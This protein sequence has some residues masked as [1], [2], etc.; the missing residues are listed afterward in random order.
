[1]CLRTCARLTANFARYL[2]PT[3]E[4]IKGIEV[5]A[6]SVARAPEASLRVE[7]IY[8]DRNE[9]QVM[10]LRQSSAGW[11]IVR[12]ETAVNVKALV[13]YGTPV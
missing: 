5:R 8:A 1:M 2:K 11:K 6:A 7:R 10:H 12:L 4:S 3:H 9:A 13:P